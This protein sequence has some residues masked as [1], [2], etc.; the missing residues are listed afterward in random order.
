M[1]WC[2][3]CAKFWNPNSLTPA[4]DCPTCG[5][6]FSPGDASSDGDQFALDDYKAPWH[7]KLMVGLAAVYLM[8][9]FIQ[10]VGWLV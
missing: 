7:F 5:H 9:R 2:E 10:M 6:R 4:G 1:P 3:S 8:W